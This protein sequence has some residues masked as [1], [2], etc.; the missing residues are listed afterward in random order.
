MS[1]KSIKLIHLFAEWQPK[2][3]GSKLLTVG[4]NRSAR[5]VAT[6]ATGAGMD[7]DYNVESCVA[8]SC[9]SFEFVDD[10][11]PPSAQV[12]A[13]LPSPVTAT[14]PTT[15]TSLNSGNELNPEALKGTASITS[16]CT[17][18]IG[19]VFGLR[20]DPQENKMTLQL[21]A[22]PSEPVRSPASDASARDAPNEVSFGAKLQRSPLT[23]RSVFSFSNLIS[24]N[25]TQFSCLADE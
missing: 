6:T 13:T 22:A 4:S 2:G 10:A 18:E 24:R 9:A 25:L 14:P 5:S 21:T 11:P 15:T 7:S 16:P 19:S 12:P 1:L 8:E 20:F 17:S 23:C 3:T